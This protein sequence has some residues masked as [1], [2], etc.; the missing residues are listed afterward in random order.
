MVSKLTK[1]VELRTGKAWVQ[2]LAANSGTCAW[3]LQPTSGPCRALPFHDV[4]H[5]H[6]QPLQAQFVA[7]SFVLVTTVPCHSVCHTA[8]SCEP[9]EIRD[10]VLFIS[11]SLLPT[12]LGTG[13][14]PTTYLL[15]KDKVTCFFQEA[16]LTLT[17]FRLKHPSPLS[18]TVYMVSSWL[19]LQGA[20]RSQPAWEELWFSDSLWFGRRRLVVRSCPAGRRTE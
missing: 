8:F 7:S 2:T 1:H 3:P 10:H 14:V 19:S 11:T 20:S 15:S 18:M 16:Q 9:L 6:P 5:P 12:V 13:W 4:P 17:L